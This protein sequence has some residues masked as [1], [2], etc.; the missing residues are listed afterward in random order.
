MENNLLT[1]IN[2]EE[3]ENYKLVYLNCVQDKQLSWKAKGIHLYLVSRKKDW[4]IYQNDLIN[5]SIDGESSLHSGIKELIKYHYIYRICRRGSFED[6]KLKSQWGYITLRNPLPKEEA[7]KMLSNGWKIYEPPKKEEDQEDENN[8]PRK[9]PSDNR[10]EILDPYS[11]KKNNTKNSIED[12]TISKEYF[13]KEKYNASGEASSI[14]HNRFSRSKNFDPGLISEKEKPQSKASLLKYSVDDQFLPPKK[15][16]KEYHINK[17]TKNILTV[18]NEVMGKNIKETSKGAYDA[19]GYINKI[20]AGTFANDK[21]EEYKQY[22][23]KPITEEQI[24]SVIKERFNKAAN[25]Y[26]YM[27]ENKKNHKSL[28]LSEF[29][30]SPFRQIKSYLFKYLMEEPKIVKYRKYQDLGDDYYPERVKQFILRYKKA[31]YGDIHFFIIDGWEKDNRPYFQHG[32]ENSLKYLKKNKE[33]F[34][35]GEPSLEEFIT[36]LCDAIES[37]VNG[38]DT[39]ITWKTITP[40]WYCDKY[41]FD[42]LAIYHSQDKNIIKDGTEYEGENRNYEDEGDE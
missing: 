40:G 1:I 18:F 32:I 5:R 16:K 7:E 9:S 27:P 36:E 12:N 13:S 23:N 31:K 39:P 17:T 35:Y 11:I 15:E 42:A 28:T 19:Q 26:D 41:A 20:I 33:L 29:F 21:G 6:A 34:K 30:W 38:G 3:D 4:K 22:K 24:I 37:R 2:Q 14:S 8:T 25:D 10:P